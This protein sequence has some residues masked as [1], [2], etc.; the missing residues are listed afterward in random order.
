MRI[1][2][3]ILLA[4]CLPAKADLIRSKRVNIKSLF[5]RGT[6]GYVLTTTD[7]GTSVGWV[8]GS[9]LSGINAAT[10]D[11]LDSLQFLRSDANDTFTGSLLTLNGNGAFAQ[12]AYFNAEI[13]DGNS[14]TADTIDWR[15][16]NHHKSTLTGN[17]TYT[18][19][20]P[21]GATTL[22]LKLV[23]D[24]TG[25]RTA[26]WP[27]TVKWPGGTA[28]TLTTTAAAVDFVSCYYDGTN[29]YCSNGL[30]FQ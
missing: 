22:T 12:S 10:L 16:G 17:V 11:G 20:A 21:G 7:A 5:P 4:M 25:S 8:N 3:F 18:F 6:N 19:T 2:L 26:T 9:S 15:T 28:P 13:D 24:A 27:A 23:Q 30:D 1:L 14:S 29:Y